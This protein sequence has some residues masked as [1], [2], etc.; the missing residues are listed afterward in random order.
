MKVVVKEEAI[1]ELIREKL[2]E[3][4]DL[5]KVLV[6]LGLKPDCACG[7]VPE[8]ME[9]ELEKTTM[10]GKELPIDVEEEYDA[11]YEDDDVYFEGIVR[12]TIREKLIESWDK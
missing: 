10:P 11:Q 2:L 5:E 1:R 9:K 4:L 6:L 12:E 3:N 8:E 7:E